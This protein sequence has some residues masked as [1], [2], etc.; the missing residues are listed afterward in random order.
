MRFKR[1]MS[2]M[3][4]LAFTACMLPSAAAGLPRAVFTV[5]EPDADGYFTMTLTFYDIETLAFQFVVN[6]DDEVVELVD[7]DSG[8]PA[9]ALEDATIKLHNWLAT[10]GMVISEEGNYF[11]FTGFLNPGSTGE[12]IKDGFIVAD[13]DGLDVFSFCFRKTEDGDPDFRLVTEASDDI[14]EEA[15]PDGAAATDGET[16]T[17]LRVEFVMP[18]GFGENSD[19]EIIPP[20]DP[21]ET[22]DPDEDPDEDEGEDEPGQELTVA[23]RLRDT[24]ILKIG[25]FA[26]AVDGRVRSIDENRGVIPY[27][28][29][30]RTYVPIRF[31]AEAMGAKVG[32]I[33]ATRTVTIEKDGMYIEMPI[34]STTYKVNGVSRTMDAAPVIN[35]GLDR[36]M[37]PIRF[38]AEALGESVHW[39]SVNRMV[40]ITSPD[41][42]WD[43]TGTLE[44]EAIANIIYYMI[45]YSSLL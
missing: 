12:G 19:T 20:T 2:L 38:V 5:T 45:I 7:M 3:L 11:T 43:E 41:A 22:E 18:E 13:S 33:A 24:V 37:V 1:A 10:A 25:S 4:L 8:A 36:T 29:G 17:A 21:D 6:Y 40:I 23:D 34:G 32:W 26:A 42:P 31:V 28:E 16:S 35:T 39:D 15:I 14:Y 44:Q 30:G 9:A 27:I